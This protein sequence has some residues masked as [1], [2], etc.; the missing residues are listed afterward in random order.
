MAFKWSTFGK[1][2]YKALKKYGQSAVLTIIDNNGIYDITTGLTTRSS[3][4]YDTDAIIKNFEINDQPIVDPED[5]EIIFHSG[6][7]PDSLPD[8][9]GENNLEI[10]ISGVLYKIKKLKVIRP[11]GVTMMYKAVAAESKDNV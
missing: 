6:S 2:T 11:A 8:L 3:T 4:N 5:I 10:N 1:K 7:E 9:M